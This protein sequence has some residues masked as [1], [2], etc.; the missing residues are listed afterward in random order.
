M[1]RLT[2]LK[3]D[4]LKRP[5]IL[6]SIVAVIVLLA[7]WYLGWMTPEASKLT[8]INQQEQ[9]LT[10]HLQTLQLQLRTDQDHS[11]LVAHDAK[12]LQA[13]A[14]AV[15]STAEAGPLTTQLYDLSTATGVSLTSLIDDTTVP[16]VAGSVIGSIPL[17]ISV[18]GP[19]QSCLR[20][21]SDIYKM[22]RLIT[23][24]AVTPTPVS[25]PSGAQP[26][27]LAYD[28]DP[29]TMNIG[30]TAYFFTT[31]SPAA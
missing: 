8:T 13:F 29:Y 11:A 16:P 20:F 10:S 1:N 28:N 3:L 30:A 21:L 2:S 23:V 18:K 12:D 22:S 4:G 24:D 9:S 7:A 6:I 5:P 31:L 27:V 17:S 15:P 19:H 26:N 25:S 14:L